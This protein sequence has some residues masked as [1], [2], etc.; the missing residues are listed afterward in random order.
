MRAR[1]ILT[2][3]VLLGSVL[4]TSAAAAHDHGG[5]DDHGQHHGGRHGDA[6]R[7]VIVVRRA[8]AA[9]HRV[10]AAEA[11]GYG[12][13]L[14]CVREPGQ[15]AMGT[16]WVNGDLVGDAV[17]DPAHP[18]AVMY[19]TTRSGH[20]RLL[21]AEYI[22]FQ[23]AWDAVHDEPPK[24]FGQMLHLTTAPNRF[25]IPAFYAIHVWAWKP[26]PAGTFEMWNPR[27]SCDHA[28]GTP[29]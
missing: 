20:R 3:L 8:T 12:E 15:G 14:T 4:L 11:A 16:H 21:G 13:F 26:N 7:A 1:S 2:T 25:G 17:L 28:P 22:V 24:L 6:A 19:E 9:F 29:I 27:V 18:E 10:A 5:G 23:E